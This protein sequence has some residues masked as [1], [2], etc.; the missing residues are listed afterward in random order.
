MS[1][2][3]SRNRAEAARLLALDALGQRQELMALAWGVREQRD[4]ATQQIASSNR[5]LLRSLALDGVADEYNASN[6]GGNQGEN[7]K[8]RIVDG[9]RSKQIAG[10]ASTRNC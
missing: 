7:A 5:A 2:T 1:L 10:F 8:P 6:R 4:R 3:T 9:R